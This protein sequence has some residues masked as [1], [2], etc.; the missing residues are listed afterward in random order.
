MATPQANDDRK[1][2]S[3]M[4]SMSGSWEDI[5]TLS[6]YILAVY[7]QVNHK[8]YSTVTFKVLYLITSILLNQLQHKIDQSCANS[9]QR[10]DRLA[11]NVKRIPDQSIEPCPYTNGEQT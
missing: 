1:S 10:I 3:T 5:P 2:Q 8:C 9:Q 11:N 6:R 7:S 4:S